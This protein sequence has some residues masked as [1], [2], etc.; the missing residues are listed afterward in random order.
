[1]AGTASAEG[2]AELAIRVTDSADT[3]ARYIVLGRWCGSSVQ[4]AW[5]DGEFRGPDAVVQA[6]R[7]LVSPN[8]DLR[9]LT[10]ALSLIGRVLDRVDTLQVDDG[11]RPWDFDA[12]PIRPASARLRRQILERPMST[13][14]ETPDTAPSTGPVLP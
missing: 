7:R 10:T 14:K 2:E 5:Q 6:L 9:E 8:D 3:T 1:M 4:V 12:R 13:A 11:Q